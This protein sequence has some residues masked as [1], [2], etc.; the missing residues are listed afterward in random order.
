MVQ[1]CQF[2]GLPNDD[3]HAHI[4]SFLEIC[5]TFKYNGVSDDAIRLRLF[6][7]PFWDKASNWL[8]SLPL[9]SITTWE[10]MNQ[11]FLAKFLLPAK[12]AKMRNYIA[13]FSQY[14]SETLYEAWDGTRKC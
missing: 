11:K 8:N 7:F 6:P 2:G 12:T 10:A 13:T 1:T 9:E 5:G 14:E 4:A 3:P